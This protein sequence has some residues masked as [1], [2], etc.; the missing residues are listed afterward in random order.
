MRNPTRRIVVGLGCVIVALFVVSIFV[1]G[2]R[3]SAQTSS[4]RI[5][6]KL[7]YTVSFQNLKDVA[8]LETHVV[9]MGKLSGR[10]VVELRGRLKTFD[11]V[12]AAFLPIDEDRTVYAD[13]DTG[14]PLFVKRTVNSGA[15]PKETNR[16]YLTTPTT[17]FDLL[18][19]VY[20]I[21]KGGGN[22]SFSL[23][24]DGETSFLTART[25]KTQRI[26]TDIREFDTYIS[27]ITGTYLESHGIKELT[28][29]LSQDEARMPILIQ[30][31]TTQGTYRAQLTS[32]EDTLPEPI[33]TTDT[34]A[35]KTPTPAPTVKPNVTPTPYR[36]NQP[37][38]PELSF[39]L[40][41]VLE[42]N[43]SRAGA[44]VGKVRFSADERK[45][46]QKQDGLKLAATVTG[47]EPGNRT[48]ALGDTITAVVNPDTLAPYQMEMKFGGD[49]KYLTQT[50]IFDA[51]AGSIAFGGAKTT[52]APVGT[53]AIL[54]LL[55][56][57]RS[58]NLRPS[59]DP[60]NRVND[61]RVAV[62]W[63]DR[64]YIFTLRPSNV[65]SIIF[66]GEKVEAQL[67]TVN[68]GNPELDQLGLKVWLSTDGQRLPLRI[69][70]GSLQA[71]L[72]SAYNGY[73]YSSRPK[74]S[75]NE[76]SSFKPNNKRSTPADFT[77]I[78]TPKPAPATPST[79]A[80][81]P[82]KRGTF[83]V[84]ANKGWQLSDIVTVASEEFQAIARGRIDI[85]GIKTGAS[86]AGVNDPESV[87]RRIYPEF[88]TGALLLR[89]RYADGNFS[90]IAPVTAAKANGLWRNFPF[91]VGQL[92]FCINDNA[93]EQNGG[94]FIVTVVFSGVPKSKR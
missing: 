29:N 30:F 15:L 38:L 26:K 41:E 76:N 84:Y 59:K 78:P 53:H 91:E 34:V 52:E 55:Y 90:N 87:S 82:T 49:L 7:S 48:F 4:F 92:E 9:S 35:V 69:V 65:S 94:Q 72:S 45:L 51:R 11:L 25:G 81:Q 79:L 63:I 31:K 19:V 13:P 67:I 21:R 68:T 88:P 50:A 46:Y 66:N 60:A 32:I 64:P 73:D 83:T 36:D 61:T 33:S 70:A 18:S 71:D 6:E 8:L 3:V 43:V 23:F 40:G 58:F 12:S 54:S 5:G 10:D 56:S 1:Q 16:N 85:N 17:S 39:E 62:F 80:I 77:S 2:S 86:A 24:E 47:V 20:A 27:V 42:Y 93:P 44:P 37:L 57:M 14:L 22:G 28:V 89:T 75:T 74:V